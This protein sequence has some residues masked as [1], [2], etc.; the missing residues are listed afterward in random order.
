M[1]NA[2]AN[3]EFTMD[4]AIQSSSVPLCV[5]AYDFFDMILLKGIPLNATF[6]FE[7]SMQFSAPLYIE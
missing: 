4:H 5:D 2:W 3:P 7:S 1:K 6:L